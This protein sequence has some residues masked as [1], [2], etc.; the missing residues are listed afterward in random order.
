VA[1]FDARSQF[2]ETGWQAG[3]GQYKP[4]ANRMSEQV[5]KGFN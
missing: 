4:T 1:V 2:G 3:L 5:S